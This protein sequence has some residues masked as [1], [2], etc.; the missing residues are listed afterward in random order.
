MGRLN[1]YE[2]L[3]VSQW[4]S[5]S[6]IKR[7][8]I[9]KIQ[10]VHPDVNNAKSAEVETAKINAAYTSIK[11]G[12]TFFLFN[13]EPAKQTNSDASTKQHKLEEE[14][15]E[16][17]KT[18]ENFDCLLEN[19]KQIYKQKINQATTT[20]QIKRELINATQ[21]NGKR[22]RARHMA[23]FEI[24]NY[25]YLSEA[26]KNSYIRRILASFSV[27]AIHVIIVEAREANALCKY[28]KDIIN[29]VMALSYMDRNR[30][31][32]YI[33]MIERAV[34]KSI[35]EQIFEAAK[36]EDEELKKIQAAKK[37]AIFQV[38][39]LYFEKIETRQEFIDYIKNCTAEDEIERTVNVAKK[40]SV[41]ISP[42]ITKKIERVITRYE[43]SVAIS[44]QLIASYT[45]KIRACK[46][47]EELD[48]YETAL[49]ILEQI[50]VNINSLTIGSIISELQK[51]IDLAENELVKQVLR[52]HKRHLEDEILIGQITEEYSHIS[53]ICFNMRTLNLDNNNYILN[54]HE[55]YKEKIIPYF[56][57]IPKDEKVK[58]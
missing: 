39:E 15:R 54:H 32:E 8:W 16:A 30:K 48:A 47:I 10:T 56:D 44:G 2:V 49:D 50:L 55:E 35:V 12:D 27:P 31:K 45:T 53:D 22:E 1:A 9:R 38:K 18:I 25:R 43:Q 57:S 14:K 28:K 51:A 40:M 23:I 29:I 26:E 33:S 21:L 4:A 19:E 24:E 46:T 3:G 42:T 58:K 5:K 20:N 13:D 41:L 37:T 6:E 34:N 36:K 7:A 52:A 17:I 11:K